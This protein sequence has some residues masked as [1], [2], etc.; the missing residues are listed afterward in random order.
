MKTI[1]KII[2]SAVLLITNITIAQNYNDVFRLSESG[3]VFG[4]RSLGMG[5]AYTAA[6]NDFSAMMFNPAGLALIKKAELY[7]G[8]NYNN[9]DNN[10]GFFNR[11]SQLSNSISK[12]GQ[13]G[14]ALPMPT[15]QGSFVLGFGYTQVK[16][17]NGTLGFSAFNSGANSYI[18]DLT[19]S[20]YMADRD[21]AFNL[22]LSYPLYTKNGTYVRDT[23]LVNGKLNQRGNILQDGSLNAWSFSAAIEVEKD[24]FV[25]ATINLYSGNFNKNKDYSE[26]D[27]NNIYPASV[28]LDPS[29]PASADFKSFTLHDRISWDIS[30]SGLSIG[31]LMKVNN[32]LNL[33]ANI[34][35]SKTFTVKETYYVNGESY[36]G[37]NKKY[38]LDPAIDSKSNYEITTPAEFTFGASYIIN[39]ITVSASATM[40]DYSNSKFRSGFDLISLD[41]KNSDI[42]SLYRSV[43]NLNAG[44]EYVLPSTNFTV[45][46]GFILMRSPFRDD[47]PEY[48]KKFLTAG[49]GIRLTKSVSVDGAYAYGWWKDYGDNYG[50]GV[51]RTY[52]DIK[53]QNI[54]TSLKYNF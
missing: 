27:V 49:I 35:F 47:P 26:E 12:L 29:E 4:A 14:V 21:I 3:I 54:I 6:G 41:N 42:K 5:N 34:K 25:G 7:T 52:Q 37:L 45:R 44:F 43:I 18:Q 2:F 31:A 28:L 50:S 8:L 16:D 19:Y 32:N 20:P 17:F 13:F 9:Y 30:G 22:A 38:F 11:N 51:S 10:V 15:I 40:I 48:D 53:N 33:A 36:F 23:T 39:N 46:G 24:I 1:L